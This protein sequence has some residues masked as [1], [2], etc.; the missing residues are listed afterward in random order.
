MNQDLTSSLVARQNVLNNQYALDKLE[1]HLQLGGLVHN[2][3]M[4]FTK[5]QVAKI[6]E[7]DE[8]TVDR[9][10]AKKS[11]ELKSNGYLIIKGKQLKDLKLN[12]VDD[13][14][15]VDILDPKSPSLGVF[16][17]RALLN[18]AMLVTESSRAKSIRSRLLDIVLDVVAEKSGGKTRFI[19]QRDADYLPTAYMEESYRKQ[20]TNALRD[21]L[22][23]GPFKYG[24]YTDKVYQAIFLENSAEYK[25]ALSLAEKDKTRETMYVEV[26]KVIASF[27]HGL[28][29]DM[30]RYFAEHGRKLKAS[31]LDQLIIQAQE[32]PYL[33]PSIEDARIRMA[34]RDLGFRAALHHKLEGYVQAVPQGDFDKFLGDKSRSLEEQLSDTRTLEVLKRLK[35]R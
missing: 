35:D 6:L 22:D 30:K 13:T 7:I 2:G 29:D 18:I 10:L 21:Y 1:E 24:L 9:Y 32:S 11:S 19:N 33:K 28:A 17:F 34:S 14:N 26:L 5:M 8:R 16:N 25:K 4:I 15:V 20:F 31:E 27:E 12:Y 3:E 23:L